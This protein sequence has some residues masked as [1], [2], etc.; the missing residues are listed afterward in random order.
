L[1]G[2]RRDAPARQRTL[3]AAIDWSYDLLE[4]DARSFF[5]RLS[6]FTGGCTFEAAGEVADPHGE[7]GDVMDLLDALLQHSLLLRDPDPGDARFRM[8]ETIREFG[9]ERLEEI[10]EG[11]RVR[12]RHAL[13]FVAL[14]EEAEPHLTG[15]EQRRWIEVLNR[16]HDNLRAALAWAIEADRGE[17][18]LRLGGALWR[19]WYGQGFLA[20]GRRWLDSV[21][22]LPSS[23]ERSLARVKGL[24]ALGGIAYWQNDFGPSDAAYVEAVDIVRELGDAGAM[25]ETLFNMAMTKAVMGEPERAMSLLEESL[26]RARQ[27]GDRRREAWALWGLSAGSMFGGDLDRAVTLSSETLRL[28]EEIRD[29]TW[30]LGNALAG[31]AGLAVMRGEP[32]VGRERVLQALEAWEDQGNALVIA[33]QLQFLGIAEI[34]L[35]RPERAVRLAGASAILREKVGGKV[36]DAFFPFEDPHET[37]A[38]GRDPETL[39]RLWTEGRAMSVHEALAYARDET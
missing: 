20:E 25:P 10:G 19:F 34:R 7:L 6:V 26:E 32:E 35:G 28:F 30:G 15:P 38:K 14:V 37:A 18:A 16:E 36:P 39:E 12:E 31:Q 33:S 22:A 11:D 5:R 29:D 1:V 24:T 2:G 13:R 3:R 21:L 9:V 17:I 8:L 4:E 27:L 23:S